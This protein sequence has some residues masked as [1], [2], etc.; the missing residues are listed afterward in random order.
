MP[1]FFLAKSPEPIRT[2]L[3]WSQACLTLDDPLER[4][5][6]AVTLAGVSSRGPVLSASKKAFFDSMGFA[7]SLQACQGQKS[8][9]L[10]NQRILQRFLLVDPKMQ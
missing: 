4:K 6:A 5:L 1:E 10:A 9:M 7:R 2:K 3:S 8:P